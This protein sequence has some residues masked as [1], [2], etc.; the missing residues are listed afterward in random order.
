MEIC[1]ESY[2]ILLI[3]VSFGEKWWAVQFLFSLIF[4]FYILIYNNFVSKYNDRN[5]KI[6]YKI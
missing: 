5:K 1:I 6:R 2:A 3:V 4:W